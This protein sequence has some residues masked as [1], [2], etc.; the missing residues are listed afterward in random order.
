MQKSQQK[1][2]GAFN[3]I[4]LDYIFDEHDPLNPWLEE[5][6]APLL[7][8]HDLDWLNDEDNEQDP[9]I[10]LI[11][12]ELSVTPSFR[13]TVDS[14]SSDCGESDKDDDSGDGGGGGDD[15]DDDDD[16]GGNGGHGCA[17]DNAGGG[18]GY[19][20][21]IGTTH[22]YHADSNYSNDI[23]SFSDLSS[24]LN[25]PSNFAPRQYEFGYEISGGKSSSI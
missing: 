12:Q 15:D 25:I 20:K 3:P 2:K 22:G 18:C 21:L 8:G 24:S 14:P 1:L 23:P 10:D 17:G 7:D 4:N 5:S 6:E 13:Y 16:D 19:Q 11:E 9:I